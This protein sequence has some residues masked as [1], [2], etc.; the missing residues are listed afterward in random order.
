MKDPR[1]SKTTPN[2]IKKEEQAVKKEEQEP[3]LSGNASPSREAV[4]REE[5]VLPASASPSRSAKRSGKTLT[6]GLTKKEEEVLPSPSAPAQPKHISKK[7]E[8]SQQS[9]APLPHP[10][11]RDYGKD[12]PDWVPLSHGRPVKNAKEKG[13]LATCFCPYPTR[14]R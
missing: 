11:E 10:A 9:K 13:A 3:L 4:K 1:S 14:T 8:G 2:I 12:V 5:F 7:E 6:A